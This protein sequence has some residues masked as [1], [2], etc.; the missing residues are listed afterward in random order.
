MN[1]KLLFLALGTLFGF[2]L[3]RAGATTQDLYAE[4]FLFENLQL[5]WVIATATA[6]GIVGVALFK[7]WRLHA[8]FQKDELA[9]AGKP[10]RRGLIA[11]SLIFGVGW[12]VSGACPGSAPA[13]LGEGKLLAGFVIGGILLGTYTYA[14]W[15]G[16]AGT[17]GANRNKAPPRVS[18]S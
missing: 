18:R 3:S 14:H 10:M 6:V 17:G 11:G 8:I 15:R 13:M 9:F 16:Q 2:L 12:G 5:L 1:P 4:L 7:R